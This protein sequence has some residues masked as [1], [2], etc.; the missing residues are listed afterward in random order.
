MCDEWHG[1]ECI[2]AMITIKVIWQQKSNCLIAALNSLC[3]TTNRWIAAW[4]MAIQSMQDHMATMLV[5]SWSTLMPWILLNRSIKYT[6]LITYL[7]RFFVPFILPCFL[8][9]SKKVPHS[10]T[11]REKF[12]S[13]RTVTNSPS[14]STGWKKSYHKKRVLSNTIV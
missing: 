10:G 13:A 1:K 8:Y 5:S 2:L 3:N 11:R 9:L 4:K 7:G 6:Y 14:A 12:Q